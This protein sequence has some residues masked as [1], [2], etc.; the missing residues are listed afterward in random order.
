MKFNALSSEKSPSQL[1]FQ[2]KMLS[3]AI[4]VSFCLLTCMT[5][6]KTHERCPAYGQA[7]VK[8]EAKS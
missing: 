6:C 3:L 5:S 4:L 8:K 7:E 2:K 1:I